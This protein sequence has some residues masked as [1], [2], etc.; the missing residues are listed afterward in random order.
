MHR[1]YTLILRAPYRLDT[2]RSKAKSSFESPRVAIAQSGDIVASVGA[3]SSSP[4][5]SV[6]TE[7]QKSVK[8]KRVRTRKLSRLTTNLLSSCVGTRAHRARAGSAA[9]EARFRLE[10]RPWSISSLAPDAVSATRCRP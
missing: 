2:E 3:I 9:D 10:Q 8:R 5:R 4:P 6:R 1:G 7:R